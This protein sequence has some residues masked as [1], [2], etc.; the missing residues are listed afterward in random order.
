MIEVIGMPKIFST[1][2]LFLKGGS[3]ASTCVADDAAVLHMNDPVAHRA[4]PGIVGHHDKGLP[5]GL[6]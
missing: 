4:D 3:G 6:V 2:K 1:G 5:V